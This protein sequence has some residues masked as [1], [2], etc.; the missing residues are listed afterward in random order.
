MKKTGMIAL[1][2]FGFIPVFSQIETM[3]IGVN[4]L[5]CSQCTRSVEK[6]L[7]QL[8][9]IKDVDMDLANT[10]GEIHLKPGVP[11]RPEAVSKAIRDAGFSVRFVELLLRNPGGYQVSGNCLSIDGLNLQIG[12]AAPSGAAQKWVLQLQGPVFGGKKLAYVKPGCGNAALQV[13]ASSV[14]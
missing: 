14:D 3:R 6:Q 13:L 5:T 12:G 7:L 11:F 9:F 2:C 10:S 1:L 8:R 4:G